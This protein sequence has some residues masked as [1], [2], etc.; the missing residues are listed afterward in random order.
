MLALCLLKRP[1]FWRRPHDVQAEL[2]LEG[3]RDAHISNVLSMLESCTGVIDAY[4]A[5]DLSLDNH[6]LPLPD[7]FLHAPEVGYRGELG[8]EQAV[9]VEHVRTMV[10]MALQ[11]RYPEDADPDAMQTFV[12]QL[13][14]ARAQVARPFCMLGPA[15]SGKSTAVEVA[16]R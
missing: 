12:R 9:V 8:P 2:Q 5:G 7:Y 10:N 1:G 15:G 14:T 13:H 3:Y 16:I 4:L 6:G 11:Q